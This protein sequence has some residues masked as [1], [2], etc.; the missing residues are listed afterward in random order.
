MTEQEPE[1][2]EEELFA[3]HALAAQAVADE[4]VDAICAKGGRVLYEKYLKKRVVPY[5][6]HRAMRDAVSMVNWLNLVRDQGEPVGPGGRA[7]NW[8]ADDEPRAVPVD[9]W[10][11]GAISVRK[12]T[13]RFVPLSSRASVKDAAG[14]DAPPSVAGT[15]RT[16]K[17]GRGR[18]G[19]KILKDRC[20]HTD[21]MIP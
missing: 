9:A 10:A 6:S 14:G 4:T 2:S 13:S 20:Y 15:S 17:S 18:P 16:R 21:I 1:L 5:I 8:Y 7:D 19:S 12:S 3:A 11:S